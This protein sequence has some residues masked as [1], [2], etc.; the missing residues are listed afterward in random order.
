MKIELAKN[1]G[2]CGGVDGA[3]KKAEAAA[4]KYGEV[5]MLGDIVHN[6]IVVKQLEKLGVRV[7]DDQNKIEKPNHFYCG[8]MARHGSWNKNYRIRVTS[9]SML[10]VRW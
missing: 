10:P 1:I 3:I 6:D 5:Q 8:P 7:V 9:S 4:Q 2:F